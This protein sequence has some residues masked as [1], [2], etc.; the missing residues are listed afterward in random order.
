M[1][2]GGHLLFFIVEL[3]M[4]KPLSAKKM[5]IAQKIGFALLILIIV[6]VTYNDILRFVPEKYLDFLPWK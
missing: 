2:D 6:T 5:E 4:R 3:I 1:L